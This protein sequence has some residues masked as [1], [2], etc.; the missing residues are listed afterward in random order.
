MIA[1][2]IFIIGVLIRHYF[3]SKHA[4]KRLPNWT[5]GLSAILFIIIMW[6]STEPFISNVENTSLGDQNSS[7]DT[8][9]ARASGFNEVKDIVSAR[10]T[11]CH[12]AEPAWEGLH[13]PPKGVVFETSEDIQLNAK[14]IFLHSGLSKSMPPGNLSGITENEREIIRKWY[15][16]AK[17]LGS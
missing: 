11:V 13:W 5:W 10:C 17:K 16:S 6:L 9:F 2:I 12:A 7:L 4:R 14:F 1:S 3:N 15:R 8:K